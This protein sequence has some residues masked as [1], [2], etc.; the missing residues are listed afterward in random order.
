MIEVLTAGERPIPGAAVVELY[1]VENWWPERT[2]ED[3]DAVVEAF[4][5]VGAWR[6]G[7]L[8]GFARAI[9]DGKFHAYLEDVVV[10]P[11]ERGTGAG[12]QLV[13]RLEAALDPVPLVSLFCHHDAAGFYEACGY[14]ATRQV[15]LHHKLANV[16]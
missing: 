13:A 5:A 12:R 16:G 14:R 3:V 9:T 7:R 1:K 10:A 11:S 4:P 2:A 15:M 8:V 6:D